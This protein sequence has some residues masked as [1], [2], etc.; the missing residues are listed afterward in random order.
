S[1]PGSRSSWPERCSPPCCCSGRCCAVAARCSETGSSCRTSPGS[2][3]G[4]WAAP[5]CSASAGALPAIARVPRWPAWA[6]CPWRHCGSSRQCWRACCCTGWSIAPDRGQGEGRLQRRDVRNGRRRAFSRTAH[7]SA[8]LMGLVRYTE[9]PTELE[10]TLTLWALLGRAT[11]IFF[12]V[13]L[14]TRLL[15]KLEIRDNSPSDLLA[16]VIA[17]GLVADSMSVGSE[18]PI[19]FLLLLVVVLV[20][21]WVIDWLQYRV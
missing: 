3:A 2:T 8:P 19:V 18:T 15:P 16:V 11:V 4:C 13:M 10:P 12:A 9:R 5:P 17:G 7:A 6:C 14:V 21:G 20:W 1:T